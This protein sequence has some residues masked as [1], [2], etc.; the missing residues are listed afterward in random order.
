MCSQRTIRTFV[1]CLKASSSNDGSP[2][3]HFPLIRAFDPSHA[4]TTVCRLVKPAAASEIK[5]FLSE[6][7][8]ME[9]HIPPS[10]LR[11]TV[12]ASSAA[13]PQTASQLTM[14]DLFSKFSVLEKFWQ[15]FRSNEVQKFVM[16]AATY[17]LQCCAA[18]VDVPA[19]MTELRTARRMCARSVELGQ[20]WLLALLPTTTPVTPILSDAF[21]PQVHLVLT[22]SAREARVEH[23]A[24][25]SVAMSTFERVRDKCI[26]LACN[27]YTERRGRQL[28]A[29]PKKTPS[30]EPQLLL[31]FV[32]ASSSGVAPNDIMRVGLALKS[33]LSKD[34]QSVTQVQG[35]TFYV[36]VS[37]FYRIDD[38]FVFFEVDASELEHAKRQHSSKR[39]DSGTA[40]EEL[41]FYL[42][43][44]LQTERVLSSADKLWLELE[45]AKPPTVAAWDDLHDLEQTLH[46][47]VRHT[48]VC[49]ANVQ[50]RI[51]PSRR[52]AV[53]G[54]VSRGTIVTEYARSKGWILINHAGNQWVRLRRDSAQWDFEPSFGAEDTCADRTVQVLPPGYFVGDLSA[55][56]FQAH[57]GDMSSLWLMLYNVTSNDA[58]TWSEHARLAQCHAIGGTIVQVRRNTF[59]AVLPEML[60]VRS[61]Q[62]LAFTRVG[63][64][65]VESPR[66]FECNTTIHSPRSLSH[67]VRM[68][69]LG[70]MAQQLFT[71]SLPDQCRRLLSGTAKVSFARTPHVRLY[72]PSTARRHGLN[73]AEAVTL[74]KSSLKLYLGWLHQLDNAHVL[75][76][77]ESSRDPLAPVKR[78]DTQKGFTRM[79]D[80]TPPD[81]SVLA[82]L[83]A[84]ITDMVSQRHADARS[85]CVARSHLSEES[86]DP[87][88]PCV[89]D[90]IQ[91]RMTD[92]GAMDKV[93]VLLADKV[94][95]AAGGAQNPNRLIAVSGLKQPEGQVNINEAFVTTQ[96]A[97][98]DFTLLHPISIFFDAVTS[99]MQSWLSGV[100]DLQALDQ[101][102]V[103]PYMQAVIASCTW[104]LESR[105]LVRTDLMWLEAALE[106]CA[107][108][109]A[110]L[111]SNKSILPL[112]IRAAQLRRKFALYRSGTSSAL[113][114]EEKLHEVIAHHATHVSALTSQNVLRAVFV[115][116]EAMAEVFIDDSEG[117]SPVGVLTPVGDGDPFCEVLAQCGAFAQIRLPSQRVQCE[118]HSFESVNGESVVWI[119]RGYIRTAGVAGPCEPDPWP[120]S[121][122]RVLSQCKEDERRIST[123]LRAL[124][125]CLSEHDFENERLDI[126]TTAQ[127]LLSQLRVAIAIGEFYTADANL[128]NAVERPHDDAGQPG[129]EADV[130][131][132]HRNVA[133]GKPA[134]L[135]TSSAGK[136]AVD[137][138]WG[139]RLEGYLACALQTSRPE[140]SIVN[141][142]EQFPWL[143]IDL[144]K[145]YH[146][147]RVIVHGATM[148]VYSVAV[149]PGSEAVLNLHEHP[150]AELD[151]M[152]RSEAVGYQSVRTRDESSDEF[153]CDNVRSRGRYVVVYIPSS[154]EAKVEVAQVEVYAALGT[155]SYAAA[156]TVGQQLVDA[157]RVAE[158]VTAPVNDKTVAGLRLLCGDQF[159]AWEQLIHLRRKLK[160]AKQATLS[161]QRR[162]AVQRLREA[163]NAAD[164][165]VARDDERR[166]S[167]VDLPIIAQLSAAIDAISAISSYLSTA[168]ANFVEQARSLCDELRRAR[169]LACLRVTISQYATQVRALIVGSPNESEIDTFLREEVWATFEPVASKLSLPQQECDA[170]IFFQCAIRDLQQAK[171]DALAVVSSTVAITRS[172]RGRATERKAH[173]NKGHKSKPG[174]STSD[175]S[176]AAAG[177]SHLLLLVLALNLKR[178]VE[179]AI[180]ALQTGWSDRTAQRCHDC[181]QKMHALAENVR[182]SSSTAGNLPLF[183]VRMLTTMHVDLLTALPS[184]KGLSWRSVTLRTQVA[185]VLGQAKTI[186]RAFEAGESM[187]NFAQVLASCK[188]SRYKGREGSKRAAETL[189]VAEMAVQNFD[190]HLG[191]DDETTQAIFSLI[192]NLPS[193]SFTLSH[194]KQWR[195]QAD[196]RLEQ[197]RRISQRGAA[198][199]SSRARVKKGH[200]KGRRKR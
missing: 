74:T 51:G 115:D 78:F 100:T 92:A 44:K 13:S 143:C 182:Q 93:G 125:N 37:T 110:K 196:G 63:R 119:L 188:P 25:L 90:V 72:A 104:H 174:R 17:L 67:D 20:Q 4:A 138:I 177:V 150:K 56:A 52:F 158:E 127:V 170:R 126:V 7:N 60:T 185:T 94:P 189:K 43:S 36:G 131:T 197:L 81:A 172:A 155:L 180:S 118:E 5:R 8:A 194:L 11:G 109:H 10:E 3:A 134:I 18:Q 98:K 22:D 58:G 112:S 65:F 139:E 77:R 35:L 166:C 176:N 187:I 68:S 164:T 86:V 102:S 95:G 129:N 59:V 84:V 130:C 153:V 148:P 162:C 132:I 15:G 80:D 23:S 128:L 70:A 199:A 83:S 96:C 111:Q 147:K 50:A 178:V 113:E 124:Q 114:C 6:F 29:R 191:V 76:S 200:H 82:E 14:R 121:L 91:F 99:R 55:I 16:L 167:A 27:D 190:A 157:V 151:S 97:E 120:P 79:L 168:E 108:P 12:D 64:N 46:P 136:D 193:C 71:L 21:C 19:N 85:L 135:S 160:G 165:A 75:K 47:I 103:K 169:S 39:T 156:E 61:D 145:E 34:Q 73:A 137:G 163:F 184:L 122:L 140:S 107:F 54:R 30:T 141:C 186:M 179:G 1:L 159:D 24:F 171:D 33:K 41:P 69:D 45:L 66:I 42:A 195:M 106:K 144:G 101:N 28:D 48:W 38:L 183:L 142:I 123:A 57:G 2:S 117:Q 116:N 175:L 62:M 32:D 105:T 149:L 49:T 88:K 192:R 40:P 133:L 173:S 154:K 161:M 26:R 181:A 87:G 53:H 152:L 146:I 198:D 9:L 89:G 31:K